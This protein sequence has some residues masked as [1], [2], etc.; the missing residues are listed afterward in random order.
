MAWSARAVIAEDEP[1]LMA[2]LRDMLA[3]LWPELTVLATAE[4]GLQAVR[5]IDEHNPDVLF[6]DIKMPGM[7]GLE[8]ARHASRRCHVVFV[9]AY[10]AHAVAAFEQGAVDYVMK[11]FSAARL[12]TTV[13]RVRERLAH[14]PAP[15]D[16]ILQALAARGRAKPFLRWITASHGKDMRLITVDEIDYLKADDKYTVIVAGDR[17][18]LV[19]R[20]IKELV[21]ELDPEAFLQIHRGT[22]VNV[23]AI[24]GVTRD[25]S[26]RL[27]VK[28]KR[29]RETLAVS[30]PYVHLFRAK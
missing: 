15:L 13:T 30:A 4:D 9:T 6:V 22:L 28:L 19:R 5:A 16:G 29:Q 27:R 24:A 1:L 21:D 3:K 18:S 25:L 26:G 7:S 12:A 23:N 14:A 11:P 20:P 2:E 10:D 8:V 17:Q